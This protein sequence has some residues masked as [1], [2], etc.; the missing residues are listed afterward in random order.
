MDFIF[1]NYD[2]I[3]T[4]IDD[5]LIH[6]PGLQTNLAHL[7]IFFQEVQAHGIVFSEKK[8]VLFQNDIDFL[9]IHVIDGHI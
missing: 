2:F 3:I 9:G 8:M 6:S 4:Y 1:G 5:I 7:E